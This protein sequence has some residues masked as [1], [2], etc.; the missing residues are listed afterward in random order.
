[1]LYQNIINITN[2]QVSITSLHKMTLYEEIT[3]LVFSP[4]FTCDKYSSFTDALLKLNDKSILLKINE[5]DMY[6]MFNSVENY[7]NFMKDAYKVIS[8]YQIVLDNWHQKVVIY[9]T[10]TDEDI[11]LVRKHCKDLFQVDNIL[12]NDG[13]FNQIMVD[14]WLDGM[15]EVNNCVI[16]LEDYIRGVDA[17]LSFRVKIH[18]LILENRYGVSYTTQYI[19]AN[20]DVDDHVVYLNSP[21]VDEYIVKNKDVIIDV[22]VVKTEKM[23]PKEFAK[24]WIDDANL[25]GK[26]NGKPSRDIYNKYKDDCPDY[27][28]ILEGDFGKLVRE[29]GYTKKKKHNINTWISDKLK[30]KK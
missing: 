25:K 14:T 27:D 18:R 2:G 9:I 10:G 8:P 22:N 7:L 19:R 15:N 16:K 1:M 29:R 6:L 26:I 23:T 4:K 12:T 3:Y 28:P 13:T 24:E 30:M 17:K 20:V 11:S 21:M 5:I